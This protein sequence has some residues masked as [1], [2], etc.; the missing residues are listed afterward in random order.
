MKYLKKLWQYPCAFV[1]GAGMFILCA[2]VFA[3]FG[4]T[5]GR[6]ELTSILLDAAYTFAEGD[7][8]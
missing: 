8:Q 2:A 4:W 7:Q 6:R 5:R 3:G 1:A